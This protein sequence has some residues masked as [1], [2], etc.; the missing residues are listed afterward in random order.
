VDA[1]AVR[2]RFVGLT[3]LRWLPTGLITSVLVLFEQQRGL[4]LAEG[5]S[6]PPSRAS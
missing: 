2:R 1:R 5:A 4:T 3:G 6:W